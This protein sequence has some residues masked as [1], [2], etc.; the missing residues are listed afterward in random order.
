MRACCRPCVPPQITTYTLRNA[1]DA[2]GCVVA[3][4]A[5]PR[6]V[7]RNVPAALGAEHLVVDV[8]AWPLFAFFARLAHHHQPERRE[9]VGVFHPCRRTWI[10]TGHCEC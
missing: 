2:V 8:D 5:Q 4:P 10:R 3:H 7:V 6:Q 1:A 9:Q